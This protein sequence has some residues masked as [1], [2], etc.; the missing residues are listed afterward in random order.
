VSLVIPP[1][2]AADQ[3]TF[4]IKK[5]D[6]TS[7]FSIVPKPS[8]LTQSQA[9][10]YNFKAIKSDNTLIST[11]SQ[12]LTVSI[13]YTPADVSGL[14]ESSLVIY[15]WDGVIW[16]ALNG[17]SV[18]ASAKTVTC[19]TSGFSDFGLFGQPVV[20]VSNSSSGGGGGGGSSGSG[21]VYNAY[22][23][24][25][26]SCADGTKV[27][28]NAGQKCP[29]E[30]IVTISNNASQKVSYTFT[31]NLK[32]GDSGKD[33]KQLQIFLNSQGILVAKKGVGSKGK[34]NTSFGE[35][36]KKA[37]AKFQEA[38]AKEILKP[39]GLTKGTGVFS[40]YTRMYINSL[41]K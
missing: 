7:F 4:Q 40:E 12:P 2:Y 37:L 6:M 28:I 16:N 27:Y 13:T 22:L 20:V 1:S 34:E 11:F 26:T 39:A 32:L 30:K 38:H 14:Q 24:Q 33:V 29:I 17:C 18:D 41:G 31:R 25:Q 3:A 9:P 36:T 19:L 21:S 35:G 10:V 15:R 8:W 23:Q 5:L